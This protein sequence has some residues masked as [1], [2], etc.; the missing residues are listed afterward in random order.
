MARPTKQGVD[1]FPLDVQFDDKVEL[2]IAEAGSDALSVLVTIWQLVYQNNGYYVENGKDLFLLI[3]RRIL[4]DIKTIEIIVNLSIDRGIFN[5]ELHKKYNIL[6]SRAIQKRYFEIAK[7][8]RIVYVDNNYLCIGIDVC[9]NFSYI[10]IN[11]SDNPLKVKGKVK[12]EVKVGFM[13]F[14][15]SYNKLT[16]MIKTD[17]EPAKK[18][19]SK[20]TNTEKENAT[21]NIKRYYDSLNNK[22]YCKKARTYLK[23]KNFNDEFGYNT[24]NN[25]HIDIQLAKQRNEK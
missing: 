10:E 8:K 16:G 21:L 3:R 9:E 2:L 11:A 4:L 24:V 6:T 1:Y 20:L 23:D 17:K 5:K 25:N 14:W 15:D 18:Y 13:D 19:W 22:K 12:E 7:R